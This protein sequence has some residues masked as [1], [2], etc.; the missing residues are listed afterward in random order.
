MESDSDL[1]FW[2]LGARRGCGKV[3]L[4]SA[5]LEG[6]SRRPTTVMEM[7]SHGGMVVAREEGVRPGRRV[8]K[9]ECGVV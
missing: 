6:H 9:V 8:G 3:F 5:R 1:G 2:I 7:G 4:G